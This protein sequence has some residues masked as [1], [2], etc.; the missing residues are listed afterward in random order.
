M[1]PQSGIARSADNEF[2]DGTGRHLLDEHAIGEGRERIV[3][4]I[5]LIGRYDIQLDRAEFRLVREM[6]ADSFHRDRGEA[7][8]GRERFCASRTDHALG[9]GNAEGG[10]AGLGVDFVEGVWLHCELAG[11]EG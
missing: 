5:G 11:R 9:H 6:G 10:K 4:G 2:G 1:Q 7:G 3:S 8:R